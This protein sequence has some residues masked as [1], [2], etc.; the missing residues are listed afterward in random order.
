MFAFNLNFFLLDR[1]TIVALWI[2]DHLVCAQLCKIL[3][4]Q[5]LTTSNSSYSS[6]LNSKMDSSFHIE[7]RT[8]RAT[9][10]SHGSRPVFQMPCERGIWRRIFNPHPSPLSIL[11]H[12][13]PLDSFSFQSSFV[14][15]SSSNF[16]SNS[17][18][19]SHFNSNLPPSSNEAISSINSFS[20][21]L[22]APTQS[23]WSSF[24]GYSDLQ[25]GRSDGL[26]HL[27]IS[28][29]ISMLA[30]TSGSTMFMSSSDPWDLHDSFSAALSMKATST[31]VKRSMD[32][33]RFKS[34]CDLHDKQFIPFSENVLWQF[35]RDL[36][37]ILLNHLVYSRSFNQ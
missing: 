36:H 23:F 14:Q 15:N 19:N 29:F 7:F 4:T 2:V 6:R 18:I 17:S 31:I 34:W 16:F 26:R 28:R 12:S 3:S 25:Q 1:T 35:L 22:N 30:S 37:N 33:L 13:I 5:F 27:A 24:F 21:S 8:G 10:E 9:V 20:P 32:L 11:S